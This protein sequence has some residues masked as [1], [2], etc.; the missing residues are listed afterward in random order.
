MKKIITLIGTLLITI[1]AFSASTVDFEAQMKSLEKEYQLLLKKEDQR[2][3]QERQIAETASS[4]LTG[5]KDL[6]KSVNASLNELQQMGKY[7]FYKD[8][9]NQL[10]A[11]YQTILSDIQKSMNDQQMIIDNFKQIQLEKEGNK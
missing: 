6:Y 1:S 7:V 10:V 8:E 3:A 4:V 2:Y 5:Q 11:K 9:Y